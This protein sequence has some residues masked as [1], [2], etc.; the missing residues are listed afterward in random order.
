MSVGQTK[1]RARCRH[2]EDTRG[3]CRASQ[4]KSKQEARVGL[5]MPAS[6]S[7]GDSVIHKAIQ[8]ANLSQS[9]SNLSRFSCT[10]EREKIYS[11][12]V[13]GVVLWAEE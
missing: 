12:C 1:H 2:A 9:V 7:N 5:T 10:N 3:T 11:A 8:C 4:V 6:D 13:A